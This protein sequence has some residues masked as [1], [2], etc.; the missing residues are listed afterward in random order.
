VHLLI[1]GGDPASRRGATP[2]RI[3]STHEVVVA[4]AKTLPFTHIADIALPPAP[5]VIVIHDIERAFPN[6]Q[7]NGVRLVLT[8]STYLLQK[9]ID[10]LHEGDRIVATADR[11]ALEQCA[12]EALQRRGAWRCFDLIR[13][14][15]PQPDGDTKDMSFVSSTP[16]NAQL[17]RAYLQGE[18]PE[19][20]R[21]CREAVALEPK[22][23]IAHLALASAY[24]EVNDAAAARTAL[25]RA[26]ALA[27]DFEAVHYESA[28]LWLAWDDLARARDGFQRAADL[29]PSFSSAY[30]NLGATLGELDDTEGALAAFEHAL[31]HDP[32]SHP[33]LNNVGVVSRELGHLERSEAAL[34]RVVALA[35]D[36]VFGHYNLGHTLFLAGRYGESLAAYEE[37]HRL[38]PHKNRRQA[39][40]MAIVRLAAGDPAGA[41][42]DLWRAADAAPPEERE[43]LLLE[44]YEI[45]H[46]WLRQQ[47]E[48]AAG[49]GA[50][51]LDRLGAEIA[52]SE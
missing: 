21:L 39:C 22:S 51:F 38:D 44:A 27:P 5:R 52:K 37:G 10:R 8:Q 2:A 18:V 47:P 7:A 42:R 35:P 48:R 14:G 46:A 41:E 30:A 32:D 45:A 1:L 26:V 23:A 12:P 43:D 49:G 31:A 25:D 13:L 36:F 17:A 4:D 16:S 50:A 33:L 11:G 9:W 3:P 29:M 24:R 19:R 34:R 40:R 28:K 6:T 20:V 15:N